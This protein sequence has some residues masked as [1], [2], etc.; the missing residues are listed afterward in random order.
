MAVLY[1]TNGEWKDISSSSNN[2]VDA[3]ENGNM[4]PVTSNAVYDAMNTKQNTLTAGTGITINGNTISASGSGV[5]ASVSG[6][7]LYLTW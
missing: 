7:V 6:S 5:S 4:S 3:V 1:K 2:A